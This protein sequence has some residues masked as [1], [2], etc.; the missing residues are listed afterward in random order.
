MI[1][2]FVLWNT[3]IKYRNIQEYQYDRSCILLI[4]ITLLLGSTQCFIGTMPD[5]QGTGLCWFYYHWSIPDKFFRNIFFHLTNFCNDPLEGYIIFLTLL[6]FLDLLIFQKKLHFP[7]RFFLFSKWSNSYILLIF[8]RC[9]LR[10]TC[11]LQKRLSKSLMNL[12]GYPF[13][14]SIVFKWDPVQTIMG[15][16]NQLVVTNL[17]C[18]PY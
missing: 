6:T 4:V 17:L 11:T 2:A 15:N 18:S 10:E 9:T 5:G 14:A 13:K 8:K 7:L 3:G 16:S 12:N 1:I